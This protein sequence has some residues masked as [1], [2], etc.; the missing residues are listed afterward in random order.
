MFLQKT[1]RKKTVVNGI[2]IHSGD[3]CTLT[4]RPAPPDTGVYF[5]RTDLPGNPSL[6]VTARNVQATSHQT[7]IGGAAFSVATIEHCLSALSALR[8]D[9]LF[10]EL[11]GPEIPIGDGS[12]RDFLQALLAVGI[13]EQDQPRKYCYIT[14]PIYF[15]EGEK[16]AYVV[17]Y[18]GLRLTVTIDFPH[19]KI[20]KQTIDIDI[21]EQSFGR[22]VANARTF[23]FMKDVEAL[24]SRGLA[25]GGSLDNCIVLDHAEI[26]NPEGLRWEDEFVRHKALDALGDL[27]T[28]EMPL[29]G[30]VV[31]YKAG[32]DIMNKLVKKVWDSPTSYRHVELGADISEEVQRYSGWTVPL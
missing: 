22:D 23:G 11:D 13:V 12:A 9:N 32:H 18:H 28:L 6:K 20:G 7:T 8:I 26:I 24:K 17:P 21:N 14:E 5:I 2:G 29:M 25:K 15:S 16:H 10:I 4:F 19:P 30:H 1:I 31:L 27:V 3:S